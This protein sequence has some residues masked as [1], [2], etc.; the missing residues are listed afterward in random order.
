MTDVRDDLEVQAL[1]REPPERFIAARDALVRSRKAADDP[2]AAAIKALRKPTVPAWAL[3]QL[4]G[5]Q[6]EAVD[7]LLDAGAELRSAQQ[8]AVSSTK[9]ARRLRD[10]TTARRA[11][12]ATLVDA[13]AGALRE[14]GRS[15]DPHLEDVSAS[16]EAASVN[17]EAAHLL[18]T[19]TFERPMRDPGGFGDVFGLQAVPDLPDE[20]HAPSERARDARDARDTR[21]T[22]R[23]RHPSRSP[24]RAALRAD[25][26]R[27]RRDR[28]AA[29]RRAGTARETADRLAAEAGAMQ[30]RLDVV[31]AKGRD[32]E[33]A[34]RAAER[35]ARAAIE[36]HDLAVAALKDAE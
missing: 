28:Q 27:L 7:A 4:G 17:E 3:D 20:P 9:H 34:A 35:A 10:A 31:E 8:A 23:D 19:G 18:R 6:S 29:A 26:D 11:A 16:L 15:P 33:R 1:F 2:S 24:D 13:A 14:A 5:P 25:A 30:A 22:V 36:A 12:V 32:A 21:R